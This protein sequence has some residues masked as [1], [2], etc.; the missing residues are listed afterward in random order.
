[1]RAQ[2][3]SLIRATLSSCPS[4]QLLLAA[5]ADVLSYVALNQNR[6]TWIAIKRPI[7]A[8]EYIDFSYDLI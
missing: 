5:L 1:M 6:Y 7:A 3:L 8:A 4:E 2:Q